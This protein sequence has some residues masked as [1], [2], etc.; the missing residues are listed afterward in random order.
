[1]PKSYRDESTLLFPAII[2]ILIASLGPQGAKFYSFSAWGE[3]L[4]TNGKSF[5]GRLR[6]GGNYG[7]IYKL[8]MK[9]VWCGKYLCYHLKIFRVKKISL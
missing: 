4:M 9:L 6:V 8:F 1:M 3:K 7:I 2:K 5:P